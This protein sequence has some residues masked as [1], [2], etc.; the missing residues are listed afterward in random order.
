[1]ESTQSTIQS[2][3]EERLLQSAAQW[4]QPATLMNTVPGVTDATL[5]IS[6]VNANVSNVKEGDATLGSQ[7]AP[8]TNGVR[9]GGT[10]FSLT[11]LAMSTHLR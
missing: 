6:G 4:P 10:Y 3:V 1:M 2:V 8:T 5:N 11:A 9:P 7:S